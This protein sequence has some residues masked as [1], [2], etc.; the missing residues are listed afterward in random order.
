MTEETIPTE[1]DEGIEDLDMK[2][3]T[4]KHA[5]NTVAIYFWHMLVQ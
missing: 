3:F 5:F 1:F 4:G 2:E